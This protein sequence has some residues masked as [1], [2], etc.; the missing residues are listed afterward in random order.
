MSSIL[1]TK[2][3]KIKDVVKTLFLS[4]VRSTVRRGGIK[5]FRNSTS[6]LLDGRLSVLKMQRGKEKSKHRNEEVESE[7]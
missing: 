7:E 4:V 1:R 6:F 2:I 5:S 3:L